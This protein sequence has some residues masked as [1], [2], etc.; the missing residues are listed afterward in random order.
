MVFVIVFR[1]GYKERVDRGLGLNAEASGG[2]YVAD[3]VG[4][5]RGDRERG[6]VF[7]QPMTADQLR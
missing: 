5:R 4:H 3:D 6:V 7:R 2:G 1:T